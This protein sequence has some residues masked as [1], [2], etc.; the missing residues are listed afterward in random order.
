MPRPK[1][2]VTRR[3]PAAVEQRL[4]ATFDVALNADDHPF[5]REELASALQGSDALVPT[6]T[7][8]LD[9]ELLH[10]AGD[11]LRM[12]ASFGAGTDHIDLE[13]ARARGI[14]VSNTPGALTEATADIAMSLILMV[15]RRLGE[16]E[17]LVRAGR[18]GGWAPTDLLGRGLAG[19]ALGIVGMGRIGQALARRARAFGLSIHYHNRR[20]LAGEDE[21]PLGARY[22]PKLDAMLGEIDI[23]SLNAPGGAET[24]DMI[25]ARRLG[26]L[27]PGAFLINTARG[28]LVNEGE[29]IDALAGGRLAGVG[30]DV[31]PS[32]PAINPR[33]FA[34][35]NA[36]L[37]PHLGS[38]TEETRA[39]MGEKVLENLEAWRDGRP[40][41]DPV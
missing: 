31:Y 30:L 41:A 8:R 21:H 3:L 15:T 17:R 5:S 10:E 32:E 25:D 7:D 11:R 12:I 2:I 23:L 38:A 13:A 6:L 35:P 24:E 4:A 18:W 14:L 36:V 26:L 34:F 9:A 29:M 28:G 33:L 37:L 40:L 16:G 39:A 27:K 19:K 20:R 1:V 22:W